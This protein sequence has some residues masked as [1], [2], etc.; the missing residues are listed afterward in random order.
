MR[1]DEPTNINPDAIKIHV[2]PD[3]AFE[4]LLYKNKAQ[5]AI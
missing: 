3:E 1:R 2:T 5:V 4:Q